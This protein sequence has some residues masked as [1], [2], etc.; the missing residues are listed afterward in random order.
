MKLYISV[1]FLSVLHQDYPASN[2]SVLLLDNSVL[3]NSNTTKMVRTKFTCFDELFNVF[4]LWKK[5]FQQQCNDIWR[6]YPF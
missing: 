4:K 6:I 1:Q 2:M 3:H 5:N